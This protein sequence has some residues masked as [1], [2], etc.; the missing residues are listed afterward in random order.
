MTILS[1]VFCI[2]MIVSVACSCGRRAGV[3]NR[4][5]EAG[6]EPAKTAYEFS[7][8][9]V[10]LA[11][12]AAARGEYLAAH[13][14]DNFDFDDETVPQRTDSSFMVRAFAEFTGLCMERPTDAAPFSKLFEKAS[15]SGEMYRMFS[16]LADK[17]LHDPNS[18]LRNDEFYA[19]ALESR[20]D[21][22]YCPEEARDAA[23]GMLALARLN[24]PGHRANEFTYVSSKGTA[25]SL[26]ALKSEFILV[27]F[28]NPGCTMCGRITEALKSSEY[29]SSMVGRGL[30]TVLAVYPDSDLDL[31]KQHSGEFPESWINAYNPN[32]E[33]LGGES[34]DLSAIPSLY[35]LDGDKT[36]L[37][38]DCTDVRTIESTMI[39][40]QRI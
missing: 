11:V 34:Y 40:K 6:G 21:S 33:I 12:D 16:A 4:P 36:V 20:I 10:P 1:R 19:A 8:P 26:Y 5:E 38:K 13:Y 7:V 2:L 37:V 28:N 35:L 29:I 17:I 32:D 39:N 25:G 30:L 18:P 23:E 15:S 27:F 24:R 9:S 22:P 14:W 3:A 31:W